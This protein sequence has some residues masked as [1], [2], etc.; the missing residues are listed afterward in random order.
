MHKNYLSLWALLLALPYS[1]AAQETVLLNQS[2]DEE[3][4]FATCLVTDSNG[5]GLTWEYNFF[6]HAAT[7]ERFFDADDWLFTPELRLE[8]GKQYILSFTAAEGVS[9]S[10]ETLTVA[11][12]TSAEAGKMTTVLQDKMDVK[13]LSN[14][15]ATEISFTV[16]TTGNYSIGFHHNTKDVMIE[17]AL[18]LDNIKLSEKSEGGNGDQEPTGGQPLGAENVRF[19]YDYNQGI[20]TLTWDAVTTTDTGATLHDGEVTYSVRRRGDS[21]PLA[22]GLS[23]C[24]YTDVVGFDDVKAS[25]Q[26]GQKRLQYYVTAETANGRSPE[27]I[28]DIHALG[29]AD[30]MPYVESFADGQY[31]HFWTESHTGSGRWT[32][33]NAADAYTHDQDGGLYTFSAMVDD[34]SST[35]YSG[36]IDITGAANP[37][38]TF[39]TFCVDPN[40]EPDELQCL[41]STDGGEYQPVWH[42]DIEHN[43]SKQ[44]VET[45]IPLDAYRSAHYLQ[46]AFAAS[47]CAQSNIIYVDNITLLDERQHDLAVSFVSLPRNLKVD[48]NRSVTVRLTNYGSEPV[49]GGDY[50]VCVSGTSD[51]LNADT[52]SSLSITAQGIDVEAGKSSDLVISGLKATRWMDESLDINATVVYDKDEYADNNISDVCTLPVKHT[53]YP[54]PSALIAEDTAQGVVLSW[55]A[56]EAPR[57]ESTSIVDS[58][59]DYEDFT[60]DNAGEWTFYQGYY[61]NVYSIEEAQYPNAGHPQAW[62][63]WNSLEAGISNRPAHSGEKMLAAFSHPHVTEDSWLISPCLSGMPQRISF[64]ARAFDAYTESFK[65]SF[66]TEDMEPDSF[67]DVRDSKTNVTKEWKEYSFDLPAGTRYFAV[68]AISND[69]LALLLDDISFVPDYLSVFEGKFLGYNIYRDGQ[70]IA[71]VAADDQSATSFVD[72]PENAQHSYRVSALWDC[73]ESDLTN[74]VSLLTTQINTPVALTTNPSTLPSYHLDGRPADS[75][76]HGI[77]VNPERKSIK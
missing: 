35:G 44:W 43:D 36:L 71:T 63:V 45:K 27:V 38:L 49:N 56:P 31:A 67:S 19:S 37:V 61:G 33:M 6:K 15:A 59:E 66:S 41:I 25:A 50:S 54:A 64:W 32:S 21:T 4:A 65:V 1:A 53:I 39:H 29:Q 11:L 9:G 46:L 5:D 48:E 3:E 10:H 68:R 73:G 42:F 51:Q 57:T 76:S 72:R 75:Q 17:G 16:A 62:T 55:T 7:S 24:S 20:A 69:A 40:G 60:I 18:T 22:T 2:F 52:N 28:S 74:A 12:G 13:A 30:P 14:P 70:L 23:T 26:M 47:H 77:I 34:E 8:A 58:F